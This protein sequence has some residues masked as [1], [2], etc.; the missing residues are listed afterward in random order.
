[1]NEFLSVNAV[2]MAACLTSYALRGNREDWRC[3]NAID[4]FRRVIGALSV[5]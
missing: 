3:W 5:R 1:M 2:A 4:L